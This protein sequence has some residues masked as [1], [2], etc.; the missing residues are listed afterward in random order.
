MNT[1]SRELAGLRN[2]STRQ[3][4]IDTACRVFSAQGFQRTSLDLI[5]LEAGVSKMTIF[6]HFKNK[7]ELVIAA[8][9]EA[10]MNSMIEIRDRATKQS[11]DARSYLSAI[12]AVLEE[13]AVN[14]E[15]YN[16]YLRASAEYVEKDCEVRATISRHIREV[17]MRFTALAIEAGFQNPT[18]VVSQLMLILRSV[19]AVNIC[20]AGAGTPVPAKKMADC[21]IRVSPAF[22]A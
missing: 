14:R 5:A 6:Y 1:N 8:I 21:V 2:V 10:H 22:A 15:L 20:P 9:E 4:I 13:K 12:F 17:E 19:Y 16:L 7:E 3:H 18:E 11:T